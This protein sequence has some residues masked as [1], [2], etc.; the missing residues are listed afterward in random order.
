MTVD[1]AQWKPMYFVKAQI[2]PMWRYAI[3]DLLRE[4]YA[5]LGLPAT[6]KGPC[7]MS[8][9]WSCWL[10]DHYEKSWNVHFTPSSDN[11]VRSVNYL[12]RY[13]KCPPLSQ[14][15][16]KHYDGKTVAF[17]YLNHRNGHHPVRRWI[18]K[19]SSIGLCNTSRTSTSG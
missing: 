19:R 14:S 10:N 15:G 6:L 11:H 18:R 2:M 16:L 7:S 5:A 12:G 9:A 8:T 4:S 17:E 3:I 13:I 1:G